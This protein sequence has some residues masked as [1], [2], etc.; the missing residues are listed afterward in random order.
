LNDERVVKR[1]S[2]NFVPTFFNNNDP[3]RDKNDVSRLLWDSIKRQM[4]LQGQGLWVI[5]P[6]GSVLGGMSAEI[7][8]HPS[9]RAGTG[10]GATWKANPKFIS[11]VLEMLDKSLLKFGPVAPRVEKA[12]PL[13]FR[14]AG[15]KPDGGVRS[16]VY[17]RADNGLVFSVPL[18]REQWAAFVPPDSA[19]RRWNIPESVARQFAPVVSIHGDTRLR[20]RPEYTKLAELNA[21]AESTNGDRMMIRLTGNWQVDWRHDGNEHSLGSASA[22]GIAVYDQRN[23]NVRK[24]LLIFDGTYG[25]TSRDGQ[26]YR[27]QAFSAVVRWRLE[28]EPE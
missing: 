4:P 7:D 12:K 17:N 19:T 10:P 9:E 2:T 1:V 6:D 14:G 11:A 26:P 24:L 8:G 5:A 13:A 20:P 22:E 3:T 25:Y 21:E 28:G 15:V 27:P 18:S 23:K 16:V